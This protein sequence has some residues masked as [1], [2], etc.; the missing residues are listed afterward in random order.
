ME[1][2]RIDLSRLI[3]SCNTLTGVLA[4]QISFDKV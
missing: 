1:M 2:P 3:R 4:F